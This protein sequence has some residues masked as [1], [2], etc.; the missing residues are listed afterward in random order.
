MGF[1]QNWTFHIKSRI[2]VHSYLDKYG[3]EL[4]DSTKTNHKFIVVV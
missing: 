4:F 3:L 2:L 1:Y